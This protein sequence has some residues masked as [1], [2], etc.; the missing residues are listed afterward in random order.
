MTVRIPSSLKWLVNRRARLK[1][2]IQTVQ[3]R[4]AEQI[5]VEKLYLE[6]LKADLEAIDQAIRLHE[7]KVNPELIASIRTPTATR[8]FGHGQITRSIF[9]A[10]RKSGGEPLSTMQL[11]LYLVAQAEFPVSH[12]ELSEIRICVGDRLRA[13][14][15]KGKIQRVPQAKTSIER[16]WTIKNWNAPSPIGRPPKENIIDS[17]LPYDGGDQIEFF[18]ASKAIA[19]Y[20]SDDI[21]EQESK[22]SQLVRLGLESAHTGRMVPHEHV[23]AWVQSKC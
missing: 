18:A 8:M 14:C 13:L 15:S 1:N 16:Y 11:T 2:E 5:E 23:L 19:S 7:I 4:L 6:A 12:K 21:T 20:I 17:K 9:I 22:R 3:V 10:L